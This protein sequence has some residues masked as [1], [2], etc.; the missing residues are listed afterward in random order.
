[1]PATVTTYLDALVRPV[2][3]RRCGRACTADRA[4]RPAPTSAHKTEPT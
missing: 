3:S 4:C 2:I 1:M